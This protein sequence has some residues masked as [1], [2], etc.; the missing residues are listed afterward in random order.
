[1]ATGADT[2][3]GNRGTILVQGTG[4]NLNPISTTV[5]A[6]VKGVE[7]NVTFEHVEL[8]GFGSIMRADVAKHTAKVEV[9]IR[10][11]KFD[12][13]LTA[14]TFFPYWIMDPSATTA[15]SGTALAAVAGA[16]DTNLEKLFKVTAYWLGTNGRTFTAIVEGV[17]F[18]GVPF[19][20]PE[21]D[22]VVMD[23]KGYGSLI[24]ITT[25]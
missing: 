3:F 21:N 19:P 1:M 7:I 9:N 6:V 18:E 24:T 8:Y 25:A 13:A 16:G 10:W 12:P 15:P 20:M 11:A 2:Y 4:S 23:M 5:L 17:Y 22:F 14:S